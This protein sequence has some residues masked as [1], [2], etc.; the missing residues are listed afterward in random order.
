MKLLSIIEKFEGFV[1][2]KEHEDAVR[3]IMTEIGLME[4][5]QEIALAFEAL[6]RAYIIA[7]KRAECAE[8]KYNA[9]VA[10]VEAEKWERLLSSKPTFPSQKEEVRDR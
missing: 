7:S 2:E 1:K 8:A 3:R 10:K 9:M 4:S 6:V 5:R